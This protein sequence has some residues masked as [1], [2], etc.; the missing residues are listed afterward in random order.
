MPAASANGLSNGSLPTTTARLAS[1]SPFF[2]P[3]QYALDAVRLLADKERHV[4]RPVRLLIVDLDLHLEL[5][6]KLLQ[7]SVKFSVVRMLE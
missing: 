2:A 1:I 7:A 3:V 4:P 5:F 6:C